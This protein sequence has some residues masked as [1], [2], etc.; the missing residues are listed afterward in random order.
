MVLV[1]NAL[2]MKFYREIKFTHSKNI[3]LLKRNF[4]RILIHVF[5]EKRS[6]IIVNDLATPSYVITIVL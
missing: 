1:V 2:A 3:L 5:V 4:Q 6:H